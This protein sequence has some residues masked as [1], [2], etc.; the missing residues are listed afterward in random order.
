MA[1]TSLLEEEV[2]G[3][4]AGGVRAVLFDVDGT[5]YSQQR[6][7]VFMAMELA[8]AA[9][10]SPVR[11]PELI[12]FVPFAA[13]V[14]SYYLAI[15]LKDDSPT[16]N[17]EKLYTQH[18]FFAYMSLATVVFILLMF[19]RIPMLYTLFNVEPSTTSPLWTIGVGGQ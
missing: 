5:L 19:T 10:R 9:L 12:L 15:G 7:R 16:Q 1:V 14:F 11:M 8:R 6:L 3:L 17:P 4:V 2:A 18:G 13:G